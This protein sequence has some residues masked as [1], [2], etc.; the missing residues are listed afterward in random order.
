MRLRAFVVAIAAA[1]IA[2]SV[3]A[4]HYAG[5]VLHPGGPIVVAALGA[6]V[7]CAE[8]FQLSF[9]HRGHTVALNLIGAFATTLA[10][11]AP[12]LAVPL[13]M[14]AAVLASNIQRR[15]AV[16]KTVFNTAQWMVWGATATLLVRAL[17]HD[18]STLLATITLLA[19]FI[20]VCNAALMCVLL[21]V[22]RTTTADIRRLLGGM[23]VSGG[24]AVGS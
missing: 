4:A 17:P 5:P 20:E 9:Y 12:P 22:L 18:P 3:L 23:A 2:A 15:N 16:I 19:V 11:A 6:L 14:G 21:A 10:I 7:F 8:Y 24:V 13:V 1:A